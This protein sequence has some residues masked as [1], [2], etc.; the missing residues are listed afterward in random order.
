[1]SVLSWSETKKTWIL[2]NIDFTGK[3]T[4]VIDFQAYLQIKYFENFMDSDCI[5]S[6]YH[7]SILNLTRCFKVISIILGKSLCKQRNVGRDQMMVKAWSVDCKILYTW[8]GLKVSVSSSFGLN[9]MNSNLLILL[10]SIL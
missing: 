1:M 3:M 5:S 8:V 9:L 10:S 2:K 6:L 7:I 4:N